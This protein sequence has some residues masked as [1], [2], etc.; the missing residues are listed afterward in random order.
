[1]HTGGAPCNSGRCLQERDQP[2][3]GRLRHP[4]RGALDAPRL[5][6]GTST[7]SSS[8]TRRFW[9]GT[10]A[11]PSFGRSA[12]GESKL[13]LPRL[14]RKHARCKGVARPIEIRRQPARILS[15]GEP[16]TE[17]MALQDEDAEPQEPAVGPE[18]GEIHQSQ[19]PSV[20]LVA[21]DALVVVHEV[22]AAIEDEP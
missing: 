15:R 9:K 2:L 17:S 21:A 22:P 10:D 12:W 14:P 20:A 7:G 19:I 6:R 8:P 11:R 5:E 16:E 18:G 4:R 13:Q 1:V 3:Q